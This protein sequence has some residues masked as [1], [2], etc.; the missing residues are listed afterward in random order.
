[1]SLSKFT[2]PISTAWLA[3]GTALAPVVAFAQDA[4]APAAETPA[5]P[6]APV[7]ALNSG[8]TA[9][10]LVSTVLVL[11]MIVPGLA[12][13]YGGLVRTKNMLSVL[14]QCLVIA[15]VIMVVW[16]VYGYSL[17]FTDGGGLNAYIG[18]FSKVFL[19]G[20]SSAS[21]TGSIPEY[22]FISFQMTCAARSSART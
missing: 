16:V 3:L 13:F 12:L 15:S 19:A 4:T 6:A 9:W 20:V 7:S 2:N 22:V 14:M 5:E 18:G 11:F 17:A 21:E 1:M 10:M 8:D